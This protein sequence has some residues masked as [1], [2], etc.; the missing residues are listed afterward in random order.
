MSEAH[1]IIPMLQYLQCTHACDA[2]RAMGG[3]NKY[4]RA[5]QAP[6][7]ATPGKATHA[8]HLFFSVAAT[9]SDRGMRSHTSSRLLLYTN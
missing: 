9:I 5:S 8:R 6:V 3:Y 1:R 2:E 4:R 7:P